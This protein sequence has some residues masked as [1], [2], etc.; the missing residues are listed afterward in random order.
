MFKANEKECEFLDKD[1]TVEEFGET[2]N[3]L[4]NNRS[5]DSDGF[6][7]PIWALQSFLGRKHFVYKSLIFWL[8]KGSLSVSQR[9]GLIL[10]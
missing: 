10:L 2:L 5:P 9:E 3:K 6:P 8:S 1:I 4:Q 7:I